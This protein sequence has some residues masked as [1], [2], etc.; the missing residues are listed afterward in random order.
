MSPRAGP[1]SAGGAGDRRRSPSPHARAGHVGVG[2]APL[3][4]GGPGR[5]RRARQP[6]SRPRLPALRPS[7]PPARPARGPAVRRDARNRAGGGNRG[8]RPRRPSRAGAGRGEGG[9]ALGGDSLGVRPGGLA[10]FGPPAHR[11]AGRRGV[12]PRRPPARARR[13]G[14]GR[15]RARPGRAGGRGDGRGPSA[16]RD[17][18]PALRARRRAPRPADSVRCAPGCMGGRGRARR[19]ARS[20]TFPSWRG[21][22]GSVRTSSRR[23]PSRSTF[24]SSEA[25]SLAA[26][27][28][29]ALWSRW[30][31]DPFGGAWPAAAF[32]LAG[33]G[34]LVAPRAARLVALAFLPLIVFSV[35]T[36][37]P[38]TAPRYGIAFLAAAPLRPR[39][40]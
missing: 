31:V 12:P 1:P 19:R 18:P 29:V 37:N 25:P 15:R 13:P 39:S 28:T 6:S 24:G 8:D 32:W 16:G 20:P 2:R 21:P 14:A 23:R 34:V 11:L 33:A 17:R 7:R 30:L 22:E 27:A 5:R 3:P 38:A 36:L 10:P 40:A 4:L 35:A 26:F 9:V